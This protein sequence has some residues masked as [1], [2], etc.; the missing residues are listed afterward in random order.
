M[1]PVKKKKSSQIM[2]VIGKIIWSLLPVLAAIAIT[3]ISWGMKAQSLQDTLDANTAYI[4]QDKLDKNK[5]EYFI[6]DNAYKI[7]SHEIRITNLED[8]LEKQITNMT[9][10]INALSNALTG[11]TASVIERNKSFDQN[12]D[13][14]KTQLFRMEDRINRP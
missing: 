8:K 3:L 2:L 9:F 1:T 6:T 7:G 4:V 14:L 13:D 10:T 12:M 5:N 11:L